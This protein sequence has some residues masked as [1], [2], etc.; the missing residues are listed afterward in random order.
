MRLSIVVPDKAVYKNG[1]SYSGLSWA[2]TP[3]NAHALQW[4]NDNQGWIEYNDG[5]PNDPIDVL[6]EWADNALLAWDAASIPPVPMPPTPQEI[7]AANID[8]ASLYLNESDFTQ[9]PDVN[10]ANK[11]EWAAYRAQVRAIAQNPPTTP[12]NFPPV[13]Q[14][15]WA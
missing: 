9:L 11:A 12:A 7:Q 14:L 3:N 4:F 6:P 13:P 8:A 5:T 15:I 10:L 1:V 2:G